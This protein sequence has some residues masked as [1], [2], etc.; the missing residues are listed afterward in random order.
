LSR[1]FCKME[2]RKNVMSSSQM[3]TCGHPLSLASSK[4]AKWLME[5]P[6]APELVLT[7]SNRA[8]SIPSF[9]NSACV[10]SSLSVLSAKLI[11]RVCLNKFPLFILFGF[12]WFYSVFVCLFLFRFFHFIK[13]F[14]FRFFHFIKMFL[15]R[16]FQIM[17]AS[18]L[19]FNFYI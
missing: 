10:C 18:L 5:Q 1:L 19:E 8:A 12:I 16:F 4:Q 14:L 7:A 6:T 3:N 15:F 2:G 17:A 13:M 9:L 11:K